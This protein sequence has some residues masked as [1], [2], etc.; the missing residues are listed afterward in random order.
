MIDKLKGVDLKGRAE[1]RQEYREGAQWIKESP[2]YK[3]LKITTPEA[4][5]HYALNTKWCTSNPKTAKKYLKEG[6]LYIIFK[7]Q[8]DGKLK[9]LYQYTYDYSQFMDILDVSVRPGKEVQRLIKPPLN[10]KLEILTG[11][12]AFVGS[13]W[14]EAEPIIA[15]DPEE[16]YYYVRNTL[17]ER[18]LEAEPII[19]KYPKWAYFYARDVLKRPWP[20]AELYIAKDPEKAYY[21]ARCILKKRFLEAEPYIAKDQQWACYYAQDILEHPWPEAEPIIVQNLAWA[22]RYAQ[23]VLKRP[24]PEAEPLIAQSPGWAC[25]YAKDVL[26]HPW[27]E[28]EPTI[29]QDLG[30]WAI[31]TQHFKIEG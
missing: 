31:Y 14:P 23:N 25:F 5:A 1:T 18:F 22:C 10:S 9:K 27:P 24:W 17:R 15:E 3:I 20:E 29:A 19:A 28:A 2:N 13:R 8:P 26:G 16:A 12:C 4:A 11:F 30:Y 21:Y 6:P 7:K